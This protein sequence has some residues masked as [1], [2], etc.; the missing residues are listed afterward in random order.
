MRSAR[1]LA[2]AAI[3][4]LAAACAAIGM[5]SVTKLNQLSPGMSPDEVQQVLGTPKSTEMQ[6]DQMVVKYTLHENWKGFV[7]YYFLFDKD[8]RLVSWSANEEE[9][10]RN[11]QQMA[12]ALAP[13]LQSQTQGST[14]TPAGPNDPDLQRWITGSYYYFSSSMVVSASSERRLVLCVDGRFRMSGEFSASGMQD[15]GGNTDWG[16][17]SQS[18]GGGRWTISG[19]RQSGTI[20]LSFANGATKNVSYRVASKADQTMAFGGVVF[21]YEGV[22][23]CN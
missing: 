20:T 8:R 11:Q 14:A 10:Q 9:Y 15:A 19:D 22:A 5:N 6:G 3:V 23:N 4:V 13:V 18:G 12:Q 1:P 2:L 21:V 16:A 17:A 7:P